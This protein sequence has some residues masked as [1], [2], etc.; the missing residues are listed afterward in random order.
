MVSLCRGIPLVWKTALSLAAIALIEVLVIAGAY[1]EGGCSADLLVRE[2]PCACPAGSLCAL[3]LRKLQAGG[4]A[5]AAGDLG[6]QV[7]TKR[8]CSGISSATARI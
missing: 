5:L 2:A 3:M 6:Y 8:E 1:C 4:K 7:D